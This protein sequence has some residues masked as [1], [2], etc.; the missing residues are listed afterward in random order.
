MDKVHVTAVLDSTINR[1]IRPRNL[2]PVPADLRNFEA[3]FFFKAHE[4]ATKR[5]K[6]GGTR[7]EFF[8][9]LE[10]CLMAEPMHVYLPYL[11]ETQD[12]KMYRVVMDLERWFNVVMGEQ[13]KVGAR[14]TEALAQR[15]PLPIAVGVS[16]GELFDL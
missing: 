14:S 7:I 11:A 2:N 15:I 3:G 6:S 13:F 4:F 16:S 5:P 8:T 1:A 12:E 9:F 10:E